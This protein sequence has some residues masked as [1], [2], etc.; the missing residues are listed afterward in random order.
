MTQPVDLEIAPRSTASY[1]GQLTD[2]NPKFYA[3]TAF[4][5]IDGT[6][7]ISFTIGGEGAD[8][9]DGFSVTESQ[10]VTF[11]ALDNCE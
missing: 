9:G 7:P 3:G 1:T 8:S 2:G 5:A 4:L 6:F 10:T 11:T